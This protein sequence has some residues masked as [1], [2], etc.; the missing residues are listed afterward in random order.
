MFQDD[1]GT[2]LHV[3]ANTIKMET[4]AAD[5]NHLPWRW[6]ITFVNLGGDGLI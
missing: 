3:L 2:I 1:G 6:V 5:I 4:V